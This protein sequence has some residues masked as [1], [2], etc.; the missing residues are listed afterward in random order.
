MKSD[1]SIFSKP[2]GGGAT[3][4]GY[5]NEAFSAPTECIKFKL[6]IVY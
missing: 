6:S 4:V 5:H 3:V 1:A 2:F